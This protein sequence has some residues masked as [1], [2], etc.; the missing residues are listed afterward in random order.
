MQVRNLCVTSQIPVVPSEHYK[1][2]DFKYLCFFWETCLQTCLPSLLLN[3]FL[4]SVLF[5]FLVYWSVCDLCTQE[6]VTTPAALFNSKQN[7][8]FA[9]A[10]CHLCFDG[11]RFLSRIRRV[12]LFLCSVDATAFFFFTVV[13][14][15]DG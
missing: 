3:L 13:G 14:C 1:K 4:L 15:V 9:F 10:L 2:N 12:Y 11:I 5:F 8:L 6:N 7:E